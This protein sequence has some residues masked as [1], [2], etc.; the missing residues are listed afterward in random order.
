MANS[1]GTAYVEIDPDLK[2]FGSKLSRGVDPHIDKLAKDVDSK[3]GGAFKRVAGVVGGI[4]L[5]GQAISF[6]KELVGLGTKVDTFGRKAQTVFEGN[7]ADVTKW[8]KTNA[9]A[10]G[11]TDDSLRGLAANF[12]DLLKPMGFTAAQ[13]ADMSTKVVGLSGALSAWSGGQRTAAEVSEILAKAMLGERDSLKELGIA[14][15]E[16]DVQGRLLAKGQEKLTGSALEQAKAVATQELIFEKSADAQK[17][18]ADGSFD[19]VKKQNA[20]KEKVAELKEDLA[21][22]LL[23]AYAAVVGFLVDKFIP[24]VEK[25]AGSLGPVKAQIGEFFATLRTGVGDGDN[26]PAIRFALKLRDV[27][28]DLRGSLSGV[29]WNSVKTGIAG[30]DWDGIGVGVSIFGAGLRLVAE[31]SDTIIRFLPLIAA[32]W[33]AVNIAQGVNN[34]IGKNSAIGLAIQTAATIALA[35][36][37]RSLAAAMATSTAA[38]A[39]QTVAMGASTT[40]TAGLGAAAGITAGSVAAMVIPAAALTGGLVLLWRAT[41]DNN[42]A[43]ATWTARGIEWARQIPVVGGA[44]AGLAQKIS[45]VTGEMLMA[46]RTTRSL[47]DRLVAYA[48]GYEA[49]VTIDASQAYRTLDELRSE[50]ASINANIDQAGPGGGNRAAADQ[51]EGEIAARERESASQEFALGSAKGPV[52]GRKGER[53]PVIAHAGEWILTDAQYDALQSGRSGGSSSSAGAG[54][55][56]IDYDR[57]AAAMARV[58]LRVG[59]DDV[60]RGLHHAGRH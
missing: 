42:E 17:A 11:L 56:A 2:G 18:W 31:H 50:L 23:P 30:V 27:Y 55:A 49:K 52:R 34:T 41:I 44:I 58:N 48:R 15:S 14:I 26:S 5:G 53:V 38:T 36:S 22:K 43:A 7:N 21:A 16:A 59:V 4:F 35:A 25:S 51:V 13:A 47:T 37:N 28:D 3:V 40:A 12:G 32:G 8:A 19:A 1:A 29:D 20:L 60:A 45:G 46:D 39:A 6:G 57:L 9:S 10:F 33:V 24:G 54:A